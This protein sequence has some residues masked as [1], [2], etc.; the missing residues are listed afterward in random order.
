[1]QEREGGGVRQEHQERVEKIIKMTIKY[2][3]KSLC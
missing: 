2:M 1:M 3:D